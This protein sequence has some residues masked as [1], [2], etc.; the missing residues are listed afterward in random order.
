MLAPTI[1]AK[2]S[3]N[4]IS[5]LRLSSSDESV[6]AVDGSNVKAVSVGNAALTAEAMCL[7]KMYSDSSSVEVKNLSYNLTSSRTAAG[8]VIARKTDEIEVGEDY[9]VQAY[10]LSPVTAEHPYPYGYSDDNLVTWESSNPS[11]CRVKNGVLM[12][13]ATGSATITAYDLTKTVSDSFTVRVVPESHLSY[14]SAEVLELAETDIDTTSSETTT[15]DIQTILSDA[16]EKGYKKVVFPANQTYFVSPVY[17][18]IYVPTQMIVDFNGSVIQIEESTM[19]QTGYRMISLNDC[20]HSEVQNAIIYGERFL[21]DGTGQES[22]VS[23][24]VT[25]ASKRSGFR[26]CTISR[27]PGFNSNFVNTNMRRVSF[28]F[29]SVEPG[30]IGDDGQDIEQE[31]SFRGKTFINISSIGGVNGLFGLGNMQGY[32]GYAYMSARVYDIFFYDTSKTFI[33]SLKNCIQYYRYPKPTNAVYCR[34][35]Y[36][37]GSAPTSGDPDFNAIAHIYSMDM[38]ERCYFKSCTFEDSFSTAMEPNGG[39]SST[40]DGCYFKDNG[41]RDPASQIDWEDGRQ[42]NKGHILKNCTFVGGGPVNLIGADGTV[43][44]NN[45]FR[46]CQLSNGDEVQNSRIFLNQFIGN[47]KTTITSKTDMVFSQNFGMDGA[48]YQITNVGS[49]NFAVREADNVFE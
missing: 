24:S 26:N 22:C 33:G 19:T 2:P 41:Y 17:G 11:V 49:V 28:P 15:T 31:Y 9:S 23:V 35:S 27:S 32:G 47:K 10:V 42:R 46:N 44:R 34:I 1:I 8:I 20:D 45:T 7:G 3:I 29:S 36:R 21:I 37:W 40:I 4:P 6:A 18:T 5:N 38:P 12:G 25:G 30:G 48:T 14:T 13:L 39:E 43:V 16:H